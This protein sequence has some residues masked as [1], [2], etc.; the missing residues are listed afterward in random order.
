MSES[1]RKKHL[2]LSEAV[3]KAYFLEKKVRELE[4]MTDKSPKLANLAQEIELLGSANAKKDQ[5]IA[6]LRQSSQLLQSNIDELEIELERVKNR[7]SAG[8][9]NS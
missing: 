8:E 4:S 1:L 2:E 9:K 3:D 6:K 5:E 7:L